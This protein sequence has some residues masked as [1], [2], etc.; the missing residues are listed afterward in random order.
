MTPPR[1][2]IG[3]AGWS[4]P[5]Q[6]RANFP[7]EGS[8]LERYASRLSV[9]EIDS[10][11]YRPHR[12]ETYIRWAATTPSDFRFSVK[13]QKA[14]THE[15][16]LVGTMPAL[17]EFL[18]QVAGLGAKLGCLLVQLPP[19]FAFDRQRFRRFAAGLR[20]RHDGPVAIEPRHASWFDAR[21]DELLARFEF[22]RV[23]ADPVLHA[24]A[25][26][27]GGWPG[28]VYLRLHGSPRRYWSSY[29]DSLLRQLASRLVL[30]QEDGV[31][32]WCV[33]DNTASG[34]AVG[35][36]LAL[37]RMLNSPSRMA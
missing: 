5:R 19:S 26:A 29:P 27:P 11:F 3:C 4:L 9:V 1:I 2:R 31:P 20:E 21:A 17:D 16:R 34:A 22:A 25:A 33:F 35:N 32:C 37:E 8:Q 24:N 13:L 12:P 14:I 28:L 15:S 7:S 36:A 18:S 10:S 30:A 6:E 23:L